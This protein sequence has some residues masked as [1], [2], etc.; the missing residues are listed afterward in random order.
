[1][2]S[3]RDAA[4]PDAAPLGWAQVIQSAV[5][6]ALAAALVVLGLPWVADT[7]WP[8]ILAQL[9]GVGPGSAAL[10]A[11]LLV[12]GLY[13]YTYTMTASLPG[14]THLR[15]L[16]VNASGSMVSNVLPGGGAAGVALTFVMFRSYGFARRAISTSIV[17]LTMW[18]ILA[19]L[20]LP[21]L[22]ALAVLL[23]PVTA[24]R[25][26]LLAAA[27]ATGI[28]L[29]LLGFFA[30]VIFSD[31]IAREVGST[32][33][34]ATAPIARRF[35]RVSHLDGLIEDHRARVAAIVRSSSIQLS[36]GLAGMF[37]CL[38]VLYVVSART[39]GLELGVVAL[40]AAY[41]FRQVLTVI[42]ITP[43]GLGV[44]EI[45]TVGIL[46]AFGGD[47]VA[48]SAAAVLYALFTHLLE[49]PLG[50]LALVGWWTGRGR[51]SPPG[52]A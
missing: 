10:M 28:G 42:A 11:G 9:E 1:M 29:L 41:A 26:V 50:A 39:V 22:G 49:V 4:G 47:P 20:A 12:L 46:V 14:L 43:G 38:F 16:M 52:G 51:R 34:S 48:A 25:T 19:R 40:F 37:G 30:G 45:G 6:I 2:T 21:V 27:V 5:G 31:R 8:Q 23:G 13:C 18:N 44:T 24:P 17:V 35:P 15:G 33:S 3:A 7:T 36:L 32:V